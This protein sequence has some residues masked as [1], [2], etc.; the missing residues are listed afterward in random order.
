MKVENI[1]VILSK[2]FL[3]ERLVVSWEERGYVERDGMHRLLKYYVLD[4]ATIK[5]VRFN[6]NPPPERVDPIAS[7][8]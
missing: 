7:E 5:A 3:W 2:L 8:E 6:A 1:I 4:V